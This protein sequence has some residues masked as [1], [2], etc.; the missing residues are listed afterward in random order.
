M[1]FREKQNKT[2]TKKTKKG[3]SFE[4]A[5]QTSASPRNGK[6]DLS[7]K[8]HGGAPRRDLRSTAGSPHQTA[9]LRQPLAQLLC[10]SGSADLDPAETPAG[11]H[12]KACGSFCVLGGNDLCSRHVAVT[13][14]LSAT[15]EEAGGGPKK[16]SGR[17]TLSVRGLCRPRS[18]G[19]AAPG[20]DPP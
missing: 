10:P 4:S 3:K 20:G 16:A 19:L 9:N 1:P 7:V 2:K 8:L 17:G 15:A 14:A 11:W 18:D 13:P 12:P 6:E 5:S